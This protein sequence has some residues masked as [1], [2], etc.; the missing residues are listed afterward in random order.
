MKTDMETDIEDMQQPQA[1][2]CLGLPEAENTSKAPSPTDHRES[3][4]PF[5]VSLLASRTVRPEISV[6]NY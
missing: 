6:P 4:A 2:A 1:Q 5:D 3:T